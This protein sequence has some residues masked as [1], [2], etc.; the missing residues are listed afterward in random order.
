MSNDV[1]DEPVLIE[2]PNAI[3]RSYR[4]I[5]TDEERKKRMKA[6]HDAAAELLKD[7]ERKK[8]NGKEK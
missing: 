2:M 1:Y 7:V 6:I 4:P 8:I 3:I 5:L